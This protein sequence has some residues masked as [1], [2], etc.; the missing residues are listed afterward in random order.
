MPRTYNECLINCP[1]YKSMGLKSI[2]CEGITDDCYIKLLFTSLE[3]RDLHRSI[4]CDNKYKNCEIYMML[5]EKYKEED[6]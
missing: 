1:F 2:S 5:E 6:I 4:F 3:K